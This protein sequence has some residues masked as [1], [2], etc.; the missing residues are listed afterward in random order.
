M[1]QDPVCLM[2]LSPRE[3]KKTFEHLGKLYYFCSS[4]CRDKFVSDPDLYLNDV[5]AMCL[6]VGV[7]GSA[8]DEAEQVVIEK[9]RSLGKHIAQ[10]KFILITG[11]CPGL[12]Y[13]CAYG[14]KQA[15]GLSVGISPALSLD[16]HIHK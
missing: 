16:E 9:S 5:K 10:R 6:T 2:K 11:A 15:G 4:P 3:A 12:P 13:E 14:A 1:V 8:G 7:M